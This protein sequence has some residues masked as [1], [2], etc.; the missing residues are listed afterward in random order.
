MKNIIKSQ[1]VTLVSL[2]TAI[3]LSVAACG[4]GGSSGGAGG[5]SAGSTIAGTVNGGNASIGTSDSSERWLVFATALIIRS[6]DATGVDD[7]TLQLIDS[8]GTVVATEMTHDGGNFAFTG[9]APGV[10]TIRVLQG[11]VVLGETDSIEVGV[12][13]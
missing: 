3:V 7:L 5:G 6:A 9:L 12:D 11:D 1:V 8:G 13:S 2:L 10:Y 4:G